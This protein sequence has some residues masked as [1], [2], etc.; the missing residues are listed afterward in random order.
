MSVVVFPA[1][2][3]P[4]NSITMGFRACSMNRPAARSARLCRGDFIVDRS[5][6]LAHVDLMADQLSVGWVTHLP[7]VASTN[8][9]HA[10][11]LRATAPGYQD[12]RAGCNADPWR[13]QVLDP[14]AHAHGPQLASRQS[15]SRMPTL[16]SPSK[17]GGP[18]GLVPHAASNASR[19][20]ML[21][22]AERD[23][24]GHRAETLGENV[25]VVQIVGG[26]RT[27]PNPRRGAQVQSRG[28]GACCRV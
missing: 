28:E 13:L 14:H 18:R 15:R 11:R 17:S 10:T 3:T 26:D 24:H 22:G 16:P 1:F 27:L 21:T 25:N 23:H 19:S 8:P 12:W 2:G 9:H 7:S 20:R 5:I 6:P 4:A